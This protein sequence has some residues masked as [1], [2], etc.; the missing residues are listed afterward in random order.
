MVQ[1][2]PELWGLSREMGTMPDPR[3]E[4]PLLHRLAKALSSLSGTHF[5]IPQMVGLETWGH[6]KLSGTPLVSPW[7]S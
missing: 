2:G 6:C 7:E 5:C 1:E 4:S 3:P